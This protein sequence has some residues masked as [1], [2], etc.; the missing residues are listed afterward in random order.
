MKCDSCGREKGESELS[1]HK[2]SCIAFCKDR[3]ECHHYRTSEKYDQLG[4]S[5]V[6]LIISGGLL[7]AQCPQCGSS[8]V[9]AWSSAAYEQ[10]G[11]LIHKSVNM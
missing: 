1:T 6:N 11:T 7:H 8:C 5:I 4:E 2:A 9:V 3:E 10:I